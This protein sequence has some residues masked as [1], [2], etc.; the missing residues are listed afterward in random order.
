MERLQLMRRACVWGGL[1][2]LVIALVCAASVLVSGWLIDA[3]ERSSGGAQAAADRSRVGDYF[4]AASA[5]FSGMALL[6]LVVTLFLQQQELRLQRHEL[7]EQREELASSRIELHR[8]AESHMRG[9]HVQLS[10]MAM[11]DPSLADVWNAFPAS[12]PVVS[13][14]HLFANL[15]FGHF[16]LAYR[17]GTYSEAELRAHARDLANSAPFLRYWDASRDAKRALPPE[18]DERRLAEIFDSVIVEMATG[19]PPGHS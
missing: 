5:V 11:E 16:L 4:G 15:T 18:S 1:S 2:L 12:P 6:I 10:R 14:Q 9:L 7:A 13:R 3:V 17:W 19:T 8:S